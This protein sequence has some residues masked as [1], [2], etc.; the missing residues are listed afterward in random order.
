MSDKQNTQLPEEHYCIACGRFGSH[1]HGLFRV[2]GRSGLLNED[3]VDSASTLAAASQ[4]FKKHALIKCDG[5]ITSTCLNEY[6]RKEI[7]QPTS[8]LSKLFSSRV[9]GRRC[10]Y[11]GH[12]IKLSRLP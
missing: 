11:C 8:P 3:V 2:D 1:T 5:E 6:L 10:D 9:R 12:I 7:S 4:R